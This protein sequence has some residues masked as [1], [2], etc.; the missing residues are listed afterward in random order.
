MRDAVGPARW[1]PVRASAWG[2][3]VGFGWAIASMI[4]DK[5]G[6]PLDYWIGGMI[7]GLVGGAVMFGLVA[8][9][10]NLVTRAR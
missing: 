7:G 4:R 2:A 3:L 5:P 6:Y 8:V 1:S 10:R 9:V